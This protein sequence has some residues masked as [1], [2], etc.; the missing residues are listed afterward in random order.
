[1]RLVGKLQYLEKTRKCSE[2]LTA[3]LETAGPRASPLLF[4]TLA[5]GPLAQ[6]QVTC[7]LAR[8]LGFRG[9]TEIDVQSG[10][11]L[12][13]LRNLGGKV[14]ERRM[15]WQSPKVD[16]GRDVEERKPE[17]FSSLRVPGLL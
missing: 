11:D 7:R 15:N 8:G 9:P 17:N 4:S 14:R 10:P 6:E 5:E 1:M 2:L 16:K 13:F 12:G 3:T